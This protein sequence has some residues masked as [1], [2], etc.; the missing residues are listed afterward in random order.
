VNSKKKLGCE[1]ANAAKPCGERAQE[2]FESMEHELTKA[3]GEFRSSVHAWSEAAYSRPR[4]AAIGARRQVW[5]RAAGWALCSV[6]VIGGAST[7]V[8]KHYQREQQ[9]KIAA[10]RAAE[11][12][13]LSAQAHELE[14][15]QQKEDVL[16]KED[17]LA[18]VNK[19]VSREVPAA[20][21]PLGR[22]M[23]GDESW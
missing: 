10:S 4:M 2:D 11:Q 1:P 17:L 19:D 6:L 16:A 9:M 21:E 12:Q 3:L 13:R 20:M 14:A 18:N 15:K 7:G 23:A 22:L 8:W 5:R